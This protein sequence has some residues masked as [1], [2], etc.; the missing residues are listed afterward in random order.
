MSVG[1]VNGD[2][3]ITIL[4]ATCIQKYIAQLEDFTDKQKEV[5]DVNGDGTISV[6]D[7]TQIQKYIVQLIDTL[8]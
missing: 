8:G 2:G 6:M 1:D 5:A 4:D 7:S 3:E